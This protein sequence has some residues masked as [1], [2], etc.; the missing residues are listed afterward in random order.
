MKSLSVSFLKKPSSTISDRLLVGRCAIVFNAPFVT[1]VSWVKKVSIPVALRSIK[2]RRPSQGI[3]DGSGRPNRS[4]WQSTECTA[5][6]EANASFGQSMKGCEYGQS[7]K[8]PM[9]SPITI[10][11]SSPRA[12][13]VEPR[14]SCTSTPHISMKQ[15]GTWSR[16]VPICLGPFNGDCRRSLRWENIPAFYFLHTS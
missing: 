2:V 9:P 10:T 7:S 14:T 3:S 6:P 12:C 11:T 13:S 4:A 15:T 16:R 8:S 1:G 5:K